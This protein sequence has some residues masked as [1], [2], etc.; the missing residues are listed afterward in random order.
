MNRDSWRLS[1]DVKILL[2]L[3]GLKL[4]IHL[5]AIKGYGYF[6]DE[7]YYLACGE[8]LAFGY[9][10]HPPMVAVVAKLATTLFGE[11]LLAIRILPALCGATITFLTGYLTRELGG[12][13][14][15]QILAAIAS[16]GA[17]VF[18]NIHNYL[19]M[20]AFDHLFWLLG[21]LV[22]VAI[23]KQDEPKLWVWFGLIA[24]LGLE[25]KVSMLFLCFG[26][27]VGLLLTPARKY[28]LSKWIWIGAGLALLLFLPNIIWQITHD[29]PTL[30]FMRN[31]QRY[32]NYQISPPEFLIQVTLE[33]NPFTLPLTVGSLFFFFVLR[34]GKPFRLLGWMFVAIL[35]LFLVQKAKPYYLAP[36]LPVLFA[37]GSVSIEILSRQRWGRFLP[38]AYA[39]ALVVGGIIVAPLAMPL[40]PEETFISYAKSLKIT[41]TKS[42]NHKMGKLPQFFAD[43]HGWE[44]MVVTVA[45][46][47]HKLPAEEQKKCGIYAQN[48]GEAGAVDFFGKRYGLPKAIC[49]HNNYFLWGPGNQTG[50]V[51]IIIGGDAEDHEQSFEEVKIEGVF[52]DDYAMPYENNLP[53][54]VCRRLKKPM[55]EVW[56]KTKHFI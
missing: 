20:N 47:F 53:I 37:A 35:G 24:G 52:V 10:D 39:T 41:G 42:E 40:L 56:P 48:Y 15:A 50:E 44:K 43:M 8:H 9:V 11:S 30:E 14:A 36:I 22:L 28:F 33:A 23:L 45:E 51:M 25:N 4:L 13:R 18:L 3:A 34:E 26:V 21:A 55:T 7:F 16:I 31:A 2:L 1:T 54:F 46:V 12:N 29:F 19:S 6:R 17:P 27:F 5:F 38:P 32:K 49:G